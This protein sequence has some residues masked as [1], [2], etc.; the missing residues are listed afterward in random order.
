MGKFHSV[1]EELQTT[2]LEV[3]K[4]WKIPQCESLLSINTYTSTTPGA[5][6]DSAS[7][8]FS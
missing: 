4:N 2:P 1:G 3:K 8:A 6:S 7:N 5:E